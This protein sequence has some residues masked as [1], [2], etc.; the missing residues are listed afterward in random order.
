MKQMTMATLLLA[1]LG[2]AEE[3]GDYEPAATNV[4]GAAHPQPHR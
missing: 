2:W 3:P 4:W 1:S